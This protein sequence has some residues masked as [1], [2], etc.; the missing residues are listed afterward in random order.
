MCPNL[1]RAFFLRHDGVVNFAAH[2][3]AE[4]AAEKVHVQ[5]ARCAE[6]AVVVVD[7]GVELHPRLDGER[8]VQ[9]DVGVRPGAV[10]AIEPER[11]T[12]ERRHFLHEGGEV[13]VIA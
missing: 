4:L 3:H 8:A 10:T 12:K 9:R 11:G 2:P 1:R 13:L 6:N 5:H 7:A